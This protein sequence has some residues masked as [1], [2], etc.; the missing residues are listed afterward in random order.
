MVTRHS[1]TPDP[2]RRY[3]DLDPDAGRVRPNNDNSRMVAACAKAREACDRLDLATA[4]LR[5]AFSGLRDEAKRLERIAQDSKRDAEAVRAAVC[6]MRDQVAGLEP[7]R[8]ISTLAE[9]LRALDAP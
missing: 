8:L 2:I 5:T 3:S 6:R 7:R 4:T 9:D 1:L